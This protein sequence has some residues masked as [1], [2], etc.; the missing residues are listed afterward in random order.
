MALVY[1]LY[2]SYLGFVDALLIAANF[3]NTCESDDCSSAI[4]L[5][6]GKK[7]PA[8][9]YYRRVSPQIDTSTRASCC[10]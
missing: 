5:W 3:P 8:K 6:D 9:G 4:S 2:S 10:L 7:L 1:R